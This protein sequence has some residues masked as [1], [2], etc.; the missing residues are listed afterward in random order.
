MYLFMAK[1]NNMTLVE[2][3]LYK[4]TI[5]RIPQLTDLVPRYKYFFKARLLLLSSNTEVPTAIPPHLSSCPC[6]RY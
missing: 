4:V 3:K 1:I 6:A 2:S 5:F